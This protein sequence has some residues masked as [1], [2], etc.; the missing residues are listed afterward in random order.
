MKFLRNCDRQWCAGRNAEPKLRYSGD[1]F[2]FTKCLVKKGRSRENC[3]IATG[4]IGENGARSPVAADDHWNTTRNQ[5]RKKI[6]ETVGVRDWDNTEIQIGIG[7]FHRLANLIAVGQKL[8][9]AKANDARG[10]C[11]AGR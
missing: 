8:F 3:R 6:A 4:E 11:R 7:N 10:S 9:A 2:H 1:I 5:W